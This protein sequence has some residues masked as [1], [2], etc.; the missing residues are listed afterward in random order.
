VQVTKGGGS[1]PAI[2]LR[3]SIT[4]AT[5]GSYGDISKAAPVTFSLAPVGANAKYSCPATT[6]TATGTETA[7]CT[8]PAGTAAGVYD[9]NVSVGGNYYAGS[10]DAALTVYDPSQAGVQ[11]GGGTVT[12]PTT[13]NTVSFGF[14]A[15]TA[16]N[17]VSGAVLEIE[18]DSTGKQTILTST[19]VSGLTVTA[20]NYPKTA[21]IT[22][23]GSVNGTSGYSFTITAIDSGGTAT[24][25]DQFGITISGPS[26]PP[27]GSFP[28]QMLLKSNAVQIGEIYLK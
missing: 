25:S 19:S 2:T 5:D 10:T 15:P 9:L 1:A 14:Q 23:T 26:P 4:E 13:G 3:A 16:K 28:P 17:K 8:F 22:G 11:W 18:T 7:T 20:G 12:N 21:T 24:D 6:A 27:V